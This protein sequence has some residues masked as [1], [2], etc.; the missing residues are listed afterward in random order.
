MAA[1]GMAIRS[2]FGAGKLVGTIDK[3][4][5]QLAD[6]AEVSAKANTEL[7]EGVAFLRDDMTENFR[8]V[9]ERLDRSDEARRDMGKTLHQITETIR[10]ES[11]ET[12]AKVGQLGERISRIEGQEWAGDERRK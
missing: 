7:K 8:A 4:G 6:H 1:I 5:R 10:T 12:N 11:K 9:N 2:A 3:F